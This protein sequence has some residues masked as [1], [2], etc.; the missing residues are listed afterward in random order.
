MKL[1][2]FPTD[3]PETFIVASMDLDQYFLK[4]RMQLDNVKVLKHDKS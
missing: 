4:I 3:L 1:R 2:Q